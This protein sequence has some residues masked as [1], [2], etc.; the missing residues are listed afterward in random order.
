MS[1]LDEV[2][3]VFAIAAAVGA[4]LG[5]ISGWSIAVRGGKTRYFQEL[6]HRCASDGMTKNQF[7]CFIGLRLALSF[8]VLA[9]IIYLIASFFLIR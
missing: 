3:E 8:G 1:N 4:I 7:A 9:V 2:G 6:A 5:Y